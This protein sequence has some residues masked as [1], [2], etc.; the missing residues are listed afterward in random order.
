MF[1]GACGK[2]WSKSSTVIHKLIETLM[3]E[4]WCKKVRFFFSFTMMSINMN[5][6]IFVLLNLFIGI[7]GLWTKYIIIYCKMWFNTPYLTQQSSKTAFNYKRWRATEETKQQQQQDAN[8]TKSV[9]CKISIA[10]LVEIYI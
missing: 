8:E 7:S 2:H 10:F 4:F 6:V 1:L 3:L 9:A 5:D